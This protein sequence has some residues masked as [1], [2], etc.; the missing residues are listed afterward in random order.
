MVVDSKDETNFQPKL[1]L[2]DRHVSKLRKAFVNNSSVHLKL[3]K[4][5]LSNTV[6]LTTIL[7]L[8]LFPLHRLAKSL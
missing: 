8:R 4:S 5:Q 3:P 6:Q 7:L 1:L 2:T